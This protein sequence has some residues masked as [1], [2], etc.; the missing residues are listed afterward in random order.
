MAFCDHSTVAGDGDLTDEPDQAK[1]DQGQQF[2]VP[3]VND[4]DEDES[5]NGD[6]GVGKEGV[7]E[8]IPVLENKEAV[9]EINE[10]SGIDDEDDGSTHESVRADDSSLESV[11]TVNDNDDDGSD[12]PDQDPRIEPEQQ[13]KPEE[14]PPQD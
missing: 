6:K 7:V 2:N 1:E 14:P 13:S 11:E 4:I 9:H 8:N 12:E 5:D 10:E 3:E